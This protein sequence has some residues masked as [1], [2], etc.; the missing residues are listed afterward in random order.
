MSQP[1]INV[2]GNYQLRQSNGFTVEMTMSQDGDRLSGF[3]RHSGGVPSDSIS[4]TVSNEHVDFNIKWSGGSE[5]HYWGDLQSGFFTG[6]WDGVLK[7]RTQDVHHPES[8]ASWE[9]TNRVFRRLV[10]A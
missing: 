2:A 8:Q 4:G 10:P 6:N 3:C 1:C 5:G 7:G 9:V